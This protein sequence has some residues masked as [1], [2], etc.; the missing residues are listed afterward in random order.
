MV[1]HLS[2]NKDGVVSLWDRAEQARRQ[3]GEAYLRME[4]TLEQTSAIEA[5]VDEA[6]RLSD[7][8]ESEEEEGR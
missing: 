6:Q 8:L 4:L 5:S 2:V 3:D 7:A 1:F